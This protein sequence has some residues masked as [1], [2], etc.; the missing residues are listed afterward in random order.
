M[1][2]KFFMFAAVGFLMG[3]II[4][5]AIAWL[6]GGTL[7][8]RSV[9]AW[10]G[11]DIA[12]VAI[13]TL[14]SGLLGAIA[15]GGVLIHETE[16]WSLARCALVHYLVIEIPYVLIALFLGWIDS[17]AGL[18]ISVAIQTVLFFIIWVIMY[19]RYRAEVR[20]LNELLKEN[21]DQEER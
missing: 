2:R 20:R 10:T 8:N 7:V 14:F 4:G 5:N 6:S 1:R 19:L 3:M 16:Q 11:S 15:M 9:V 12:A 17:G 18:L 21:R 13:Q